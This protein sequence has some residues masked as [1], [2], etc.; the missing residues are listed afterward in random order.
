MSKTT[1]PIAGQ[2]PPAYGG[3]AILS[4]AYRVFFPAAALWAVASLA[5]WLLYVS[6]L[7]G[8]FGANQ[9]M[10]IWHAHELVYGYGGAV[11]AGFA[12][13][14]IPNWTGR[15]PV[16]GAELLL[17]FALWFV[18][19]ATAVMLLYGVDAEHPRAVA[20]IAFYGLFVLVAAREIIGGKN[21]RNLKIVAV[22]LLLVAAAL[23]ANMQRLGVFSS[24]L[25]GWETGLSVLLLLICVIGGRIIPAFTTNWMRGQGIEKLPVMFNHFDALAIVVAAAVLAAYLLGAG[26]PF[27]TLAAA[28]AAAFH[29]VRL[30]RWRGFAT[31]KSPIVTAL[32]VS[33]FWVP[34]GFLLLAFAEADFISDIAALHAFAVGGI[35]STTLAVMTRASL[36]HAGLPLADSKL[37]TSIYM[38]VNLSAISRVVATLWFSEYENFLSI[39]GLLWLAAFLL[40]LWKFGPLAFQRRN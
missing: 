38:A 3:P 31:L 32:H 9:N 14:A 11:V 4:G 1:I 17:L 13:T 15:T 16:R 12:L 6:S 27:F 35:G 34:T 29:Y 2:T 22:F 24:A 30:Y 26:G 36:G 39:S 33:Y 5:L 10:M 25:S 20:E 18:A 21:W 28:V 37:L 40:F 8:D 7:G 19:R 23:A